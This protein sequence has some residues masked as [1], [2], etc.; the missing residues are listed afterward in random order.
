M[1]N[2]GFGRLFI[3]ADEE[4]DTNDKR[5]NQGLDG[6]YGWIIILDAMSGGR[7]EVWKYFEDMNVVEFLGQ[8][9]YYKEKQD[10]QRAEQQKRDGILR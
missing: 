3:E 8:C 7:P 10:L 2:K 1:L 4:D 9:Q 6:R 5:V